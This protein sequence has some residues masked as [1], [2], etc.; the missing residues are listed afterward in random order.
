MVSFIEKLSFIGGFYVYFLSHI[1]IYYVIVGSDG[2]RDP[3][4]RSSSISED[5]LQFLGRPHHMEKRF[6]VDRRKLEKLIKGG[7]GVSAQVGVVYHVSAQHRWVRCI[8]ISGNGV[9]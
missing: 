5:Y 3:L 6:P 9:S 2:V 7:C 8:N 1:I 4:V